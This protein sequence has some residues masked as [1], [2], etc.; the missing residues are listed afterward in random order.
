MVRK[1]DPDDQRQSQPESLTAI[2]I[3]S[4]GDL[5]VGADVTLAEHDVFALQSEF[6]ALRHRITGVQREIEDRRCELTGVD[7]SGRDVIGQYRVD[8]D[9][10]AQ[11]RP[12]QPGGIDQQR[13]DVDFARLQRLQAREREQVR[14]QLGAAG[15]GLVDQLGNCGEIRTVCDL[16]AKNLD[17]AG[18][19]G[20]NI[21]EVMSDAAG[22][23]TDRLHLLGLTNLPFRRFHLTERPKP[24][25]GAAALPAFF[26]KG[27]L[28]LAKLGWRGNGK[29]L[30]QQLPQQCGGDDRCDSGQRLDQAFDSVDRHPERINSEYVGET[31]RRNEDSESPEDPVELDV[32]PFRYKEG[33]GKGN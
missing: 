30:W 16:L 1:P 9:V 20:E 18:N 22:Q 12:Q 10:F 31:A 6:A 21:V 14:R 2:D 23:L 19:D 5:A 15:G 13:I 29:K 26:F 27:S 11:R 4:G 8:F 33:K 3:V 7:E 25:L 24:V 32:A 17:G 28:C